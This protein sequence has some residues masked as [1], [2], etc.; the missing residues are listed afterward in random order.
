MQAMDVVP[1]ASSSGTATPFTSP[2]L[3]ATAPPYPIAQIGMGDA[4]PPAPTFTTPIKARVITKEDGLRMRELEV[5]T[6]DYGASEVRPVPEEPPRPKNARPR[7]QN[8]HTPV[9]RTLD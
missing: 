8:F 6:A 1:P 9:T 5:Q 4:L 7:P 3:R 2:I